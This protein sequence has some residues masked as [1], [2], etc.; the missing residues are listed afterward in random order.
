MWKRQLTTSQKLQSIGLIVCGLICMGTSGSCEG[1]MGSCDYGDDVSN[2]R[3]VL[4]DEPAPSVSGVTIEAAGWVLEEIPL[5]GSPDVRLIQWYE[6][7]K[8][9]FM[10]DSQH[11]LH[12]S[13]P[14]TYLPERIVSTRA[15]TNSPAHTYAMFTTVTSNALDPVTFILRE[16]DAQ[17]ELEVARVP[18]SNGQD[19]EV[20]VSG[21]PLPAPGQ[22]GA[23]Y[24]DVYARLV[25]ALP[26]SGVPAN[27]QDD[28]S[29]AGH[30]L[31]FDEHGT[32][33]GI[34]SSP[35]NP[36]ICDGLSNP[37]GFFTFLSTT[38]LLDRRDGVNEVVLRQESNNLDFGWPMASGSQVPS[39]PIAEWMPSRS[40]RLAQQ[41]VG[42][43]IFDSDGEID[44]WSKLLQPALIAHNELDNTIE[45]I[46]FSTSTGAGAAS[47][48]LHL[49]TRELTSLSV[50]HNHT[51][52][53]IDGGLYKFRIWGSD[54]RN[55]YTNTCNP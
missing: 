31:S 29:F 36:A 49:N 4:N 6:R 19:V 18:G 46:E 16:N 20:I 12:I 51:L 41:V 7:E 1:C 42:E 37:Q 10:L 45:R 48:L 8:R 27:A 34:P 17:T 21:L 52:L 32:P 38:L 5:G 55:D 47:T 23:I 28:Q 13:F 43:L 33:M 53:A 30:L 50:T 11:R 24:S 15:D 25:V 22:Q 44:Y 2:C 9:L 39:Q 3:F 54:R 35:T 26:D 40:Y 14:Q